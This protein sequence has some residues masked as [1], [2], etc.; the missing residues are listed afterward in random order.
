MTDTT[1]P[2]REAFETW[3]EIPHTRRS[4]AARR[5]Q[6]EPFLAGWIAGQ[7]PRR[8]KPPS[9][10]RCDSGLVDTGGEC[11]ACDAIQGEACQRP[12]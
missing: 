1:S 2:A 3:C 9:D 4:R 12:E 6:W 8:G 5:Q 10:R 11:I 7:A